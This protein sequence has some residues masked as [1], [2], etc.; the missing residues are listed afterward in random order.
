MRIIVNGSNG[1]MGKEV[2]TLAKDGY[3]GAELVAA[4]DR[5]NSKSDLNQTYSRLDEFWGEASC[6]I[7]FTN[8]EQTRDLIDYAV[9]RKLPLV[10]ATTGQ[11]QEEI[12]TIIEAGK[13][14]P[15][16]YSANMSVGVAILVE[17][18]KT[19]AR[20]MNDADIEII[21]RHHNRKVDAPSGTALMLADAIKEVR[22]DAEYVMGR[23]GY[24]KRKKN[25]IGI[26]AI[27]MGNIFG[28][29]EV[30]VGTDTQTISIKHEVHDRALFAEGALV[31]AEFIVNKG[32]GIYGMQDMV[33]VQ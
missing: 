11:T 15:I 23:N 13:N 4:V 20:L 14:I 27:R 3:R 6:I 28:D 1:R 22:K 16:F 25:E 24:E 12:N 19:T 21:D 29:H 18:A 5:K 2:L 32:P 30:I 17:L 10:I 31:A 33:K 8:H 9:K 26:H 7:D